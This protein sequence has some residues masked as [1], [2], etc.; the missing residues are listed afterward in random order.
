MN[1]MQDLFELGGFV[2]R[3]CKSRESAILARVPLELVD[4]QSTRSIDIDHFTMV[5]GIEWNVTLDTNSTSGFIADAG[6]DTNRIV[7]RLGLVLS[8]DSQSEILLQYMWRKKEI[9]M[10][11]F[12]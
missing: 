2:L 11:L 12:R 3:K 1:E 8:S 5:L 10:T 7:R 6:I 4:S 9:G